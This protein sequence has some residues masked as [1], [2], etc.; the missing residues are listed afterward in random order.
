MK[1]DKVQE[2][3]FTDY[4][5]GLMDKGQAASIEKHVSECA[6][7]REV[8]EAVLATRSSLKS[9]RREE[10]PSYIWYRVKEAI[11]SERKEEKNVLGGVLDTIRDLLT[12]PRYVFAR[13]TAVALII[14]VLVFAGFAVQRHSMTRNISSSDMSGLVNFELNGDDVP[15]DLGTDIEKCFL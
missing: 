7:C 5:D 4:I 2:F 11:M 14:L 3:L 1:C 8:K 13:A 10:P 12:G 9:I 15:Q 6:K